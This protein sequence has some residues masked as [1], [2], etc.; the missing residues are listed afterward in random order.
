MTAG[1]VMGVDA[2]PGGWVGVVLDRDRAIGRFAPTLAE[3]VGPADDD[4]RVIA[5]D[6]PIGLPD[7][8]LRQADVLVRLALGPR[9]SSLFMTPVRAA[10]VASTYDEAN[11]INR[12][13]VGKGV[14]RQSFGLRDRVLDADEFVVNRP[15][16]VIE[17]HPEL[18]FATMAGTPLAHAK[19]TWVGARRRRELLRANGIVLDEV[20][21]EVGPAGVDDVLDAAA[22]A[23]TAR[24]RD[25]GTAIAHPQPPQVFSDGISCAIW[26]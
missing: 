26:A 2:C 15:E 18:S 24:R 6:I 21:P 8:S 16:S 7:T 14:S 17:V 11:A 12:R 25:G 3:L 23:W 5:I 22:A 4:L 19:R 10:V 1:R 13:L 20:G 9:R